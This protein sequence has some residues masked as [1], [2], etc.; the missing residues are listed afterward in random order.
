MQS[1]L[2]W[3]LIIIFL[4]VLQWIWNKS[5]SKIFH[6]NSSIFFSCTTFLAQPGKFEELKDALQ[7]IHKHKTNHF[8]HF[9]V[10][11]EYN[12]TNNSTK[13]KNQ[14]QYLK[15]QYPYINF[16]NKTKND[17]G[18]ARSLNIILEAA[19]KSCCKYWVQWEEGWYITDEKPSL[20]P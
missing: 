8:K 1:Q 6:P 4:L 18:Q 2:I 10:I 19:Q 5:S 15:I 7:S 17:V 20:F 3:L 16:I 12:P 9:L 13:I 14:L 11:N